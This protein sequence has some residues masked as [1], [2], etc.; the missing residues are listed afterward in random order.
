M[1]E[2]LLGFGADPNSTSETRDNA[3]HVAVHSGNARLVQLLL[4]AGAKPDYV[5]DIGETVFD[6]LPEDIAQRTAIVRVLEEHHVKR[7]S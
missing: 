7:P 1:A 5:T 2:I 4:S 3:L 6:A